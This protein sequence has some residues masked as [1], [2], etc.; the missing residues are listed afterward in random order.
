MIFSDQIQLVQNCTSLQ[1][2]RKV[3]DMRNW[4][5][6]RLDDVIQRFIITAWTPVSRFFL[7][8]GE[9]MTSYLMM[10]D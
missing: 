6:V 2:G 7:P 3:L 4:V 5:P 10:V 8:C 9:V 1:S